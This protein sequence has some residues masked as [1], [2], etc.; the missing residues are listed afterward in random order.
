M[1][2]VSERK[3]TAKS[4]KAASR[5]AGPAQ[6]VIDLFAP[7]MTPLLRA[8]LGGL[9]AALRFVRLEQ[10]PSAAWPSP[11]SIG[12]GRATVDARR[13]TIEWN[14]ASPRD[15]LQTLFSKAFRISSG[16]I[17]T[18]A[19]TFEPTSPMPRPLAIVLQEGLKRTFL[20][21]GKT[22][23]KVG[24]RK[25]A[26][27]EIDDNRF[28]FEWQ[29]YSSFVHQG[30]W[31]EV[32]KALRRDAVALASW[33]YPGAAQ[34]HKYGET[35]CEYGAGE[36]LSACFALI[37]CLSFEARPGRMGA[38]VIPEPSD[39]I[40][41]AVTRTRLTPA[42]PADA[43][44]AS[45][46]DAVLRTQLALR[47]DDIARHR[48]IAATHGILLKTLPWAS[49]QKSRCRTLGVE[50][51]PAVTLDVF[52]RISRTLP[53]RLLAKPTS[54]D[55]ESDGGYFVA[56][57]A[58]RAFVTDNLAAGRPWFAG[59]ATATTGGKKPR[60]IHYYRDRDN[61]GALYPEEKK[62]LTIMNETL[63]DAEKA[64]VTSV[65]TAIRQRF[66]RIFQETEQ[67]PA[68]TRKN[69]FAG[70]RERW[71]LAFAGAK[72]HDQIRGALASLW[73]LAGPNQ[74][75]R[76]SWQQIVPL[77]RPKH[78]QAARDLALVALAS[79][80]S[81]SPLENATSEDLSAE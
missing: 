56:T 54:E 70:E 1:A 30:A 38:L 71:R 7:G 19:G 75:L 80:R 34:T 32:D 60:F 52:D 68:Q 55:E 47:M 9:A 31:G 69:R 23:K 14:G 40:E 10:D 5:A 53:A 16:G 11:I 59:F 51:V 77:L 4:G 28:T 24:K 15:V 20:Q 3:R 41:F 22:T 76:D 49:Q 36:A 65:H 12:R 81:A 39:L 33:A 50:S 62:G 78:W 42:R 6:L 17:V 48:G 8:G 61:H 79:Y 66:G 35:R 37:G 21:H 27:E 29:P 2:R 46:G 43:F 74:E 45:L 64:L 57:S 58:L 26:S 18:L 73:S 13:I 44:V 25:T 63:D 67:L 72:T